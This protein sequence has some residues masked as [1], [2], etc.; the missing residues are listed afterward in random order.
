[1]RLEGTFDVKAPRQQVWERITDPS[2]MVG[3]I[4]GCESIEQVDQATY[5]AV[6]AVSIGIVKARFHLVVQITREDP[7][8]AIYAKTTGE[9]G[10]QASMVTAENI[11]TLIELPENETRIEYSSDVSIS[12]RL[13]KYGLG[14]MRKRAAR[15]S[16]EFATNFQ[17]KLEGSAE[18]TSPSVPAGRAKTGKGGML[19]WFRPG[20]ASQQTAAPEPQPGAPAASVGAKVRAA[21]G[22]VLRPKT[23]EDAVAML[24]EGKQS[25]PLSGGA[26][27]IAMKNAG[28]VDAGVFISLEAIDALHGIDV[29]PD[30]S[31]RI[32]AMTRHRDTA[33]S[34]HLTGSLEVIRKAAQVIANPPVRNMGTIGG[35]VANADPA[36]DYLPAL[37]CTDARVELVGLE[38]Q[39]I[40]ALSEFLVDWHTTALRPAEIITA[41]ELPASQPGF[42]AYRKVA[43]VSGDFATASCAVSFTAGAKS[44]RARVAIGACGPYPV[45]DLEAEEKLSNSSMDEADIAAFAARLV[46][47]YDPIDDVRGSADYRR[48]LIPRLVRE[49]LAQL[50]VQEEAA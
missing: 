28:L 10:T 24:A 49:A 18:P 7:P 13:G 47:L 41:I 19:S 46:E 5:K 29:R 3:C 9:E 30:G 32:G 40:M 8:N 34:Q 42:S 39:R 2:L 31:I 22:T 33:A 4:P 23:V 36:A 38:G 37:I 15:L 35:S 27:L 14:I 1:M 25:Y 50:P 43:R 6:V 26:T 11:V 45:R 44:P 17:A 20:Q 48:L 12:G 21:N 16:D